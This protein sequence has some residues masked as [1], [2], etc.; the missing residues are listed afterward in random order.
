VAVTFNLYLGGARFSYQKGQRS[1]WKILEL[2][3]KSEGSIWIMWQRL[4]F[5]FFHI[6]YS[7]VPPFVAM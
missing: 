1:A 7:S 4:P 2:S 3:A 6:C 5:K